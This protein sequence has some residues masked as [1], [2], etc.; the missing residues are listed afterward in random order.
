MKVPFVDAKS[1][2]CNVLSG[3]RLTSQWKLE[4]HASATRKSLVGLRPKRFS[5]GINSKANGLPNQLKTRR[6][7]GFVRP[8]G[9]RPNLGGLRNISK[10]EPLEK[11][12]F[13]YETGDRLFWGR[14]FSGDAC[15]CARLRANA[16]CRGRLRQNRLM[17]RAPPNRGKAV[18]PCA[19]L[20]RYLHHT[21]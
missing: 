5:P 8:A 10:T 15:V 19:R 13:G 17:A 11:R 20:R 18:R 14:A 7:I 21:A 2:T 1:C 12:R 6:S 9:K 3:F 4:I 16:R